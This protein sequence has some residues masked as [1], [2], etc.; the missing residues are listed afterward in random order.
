MKKPEKVTVTH[1]RYNDLI[2]YIEEKYNID[3]RDYYGMFSDKG[4]PWLVEGEDPPYADFWHWVVQYIEGMS[5]GSYVYLPPIWEEVEDDPQCY[6]KDR[7]ST[8]RFVVEILD[9]LTKEFGED[10]LNEQLWVEW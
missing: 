5:N 3:T 4:R 1:Y 2:E 8:P 6:Q 10:I 7:N 9:L